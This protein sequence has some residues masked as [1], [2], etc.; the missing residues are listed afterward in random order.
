M[1]WENEAAD[2]IQ[3]GC[4]QYHVMDRFAIKMQTNN[5]NCWNVCGF[6]DMASPRHSHS[7]YNNF[8]KVHQ[9]LLFFPWCEFFSPMVLPLPLR[10]CTIPLHVAS[11]SRRWADSYH[12]RMGSLP[13]SCSGPFHFNRFNV[14]LTRH[15]LPRSLSFGNSFSLSSFWRF[16]A[17]M[18]LLKWAGDGECGGIRAFHIYATTDNNNGSKW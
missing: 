5:N 14:A 18:C 4:S 12:F 2:G 3:F 1:Q 11:V 16:L 15:R 8:H 7:H 17:K 6:D 10:V 13:L 9:N